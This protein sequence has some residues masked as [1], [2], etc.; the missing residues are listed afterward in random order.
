MYWALLVIGASMLYAIGN[1]ISKYF[2]I[3]L[4]IKTVII[5]AFA[6][7]SV[8]L[9]VL[10]VQPLTFS[11]VALLAGILA[12]IGQLIFYHALSQYEI[13]KTIALLFMSSIF[14]AIISAVSLGEILTPWQ[15]AGIIL[16]VVGAI[17]ISVEGITFRRGA[18]FAI[19]ASV[20]FALC[21]ILSKAALEEINAPNVFVWY[22]VPYM[23]IAI[24]G[25]LI[26][27]RQLDLRSKG[28]VLGCFISG[29][30]FAGGTYIFTTSLAYTQ[31]ALAS[32]LTS[33]TPFFVFLI[34]TVITKINP[35]L[36]EEDI[37]HKSLATK[38]LAIL[39][40]AIGV[41]LV[42]S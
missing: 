1:I 36:L 19:L 37:N 32:A 10:L 26:W 34:S 16:S 35:R 3:N 25:A 40:L 2:V 41:Y 24:V 13:S 8:A 14:V 7:S 5:C 27:K 6:G 20:V 4:D 12:V 39:L 18:L 11:W 17:A 29:V 22:Q 15:Y 30:F 33:A 28:K 42:T 31:V 9:F 23:A 38:A 21:D